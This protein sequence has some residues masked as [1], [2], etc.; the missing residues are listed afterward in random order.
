MF[1]FLDEATKH[2]SLHKDLHKAAHRLGRDRL[3]ETLASEGAGDWRRRRGRVAVF[4]F[5]HEEEL[6]VADH[7]HEEANEG[8][9][10]HRAQVAGV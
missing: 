8:L 2:L 10:H 3:A 4:S 1:P 7:L 9:R 6:I 5:A